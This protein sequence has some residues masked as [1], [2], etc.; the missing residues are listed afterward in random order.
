MSKLSKHTVAIF[1]A[2]ILSLSITACGDRETPAKTQEDVAKA[3]AEGAKDVAKERAKVTENMT[4]AQKDVNKADTEYGHEAAKANRDLAIT[5][6]EALHK[7]T[8]EQCEALT[9]DDRALCKKQADANL[10]QAKVQ[11]QVTEN[12]TDPK[13]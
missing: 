6:A 8:I 11:A 13:Q 10:E 7:V 5:E 12:A 9:G 2:C 3:Q 1:S 4:E